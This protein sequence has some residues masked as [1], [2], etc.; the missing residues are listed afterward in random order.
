MTPGVSKLVHLIFV[1]GYHAAKHSHIDTVTKRF[2]P[3]VTTTSTDARK[4]ACAA[5]EN[6]HARIF[7]ESVLLPDHRTIAKNGTPD[8]VRGFEEGTA[9]FLSLHA[10]FVK[11][12]AVWPTHASAAHVVIPVAQ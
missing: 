10:V 9:G 1:L 8:T 5:H 12:T 3:V 4:D 7:L 6:R 2:E 11:A